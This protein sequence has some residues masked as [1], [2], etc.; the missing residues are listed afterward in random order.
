MIAD[1]W[2]LQR[3]ALLGILLCWVA[4]GFGFAHWDHAAAAVGGWALCWTLLAWCALNAGTLW[5]N[6]SVDRDAGEV[7]LGRSVPLPP[8][9]RTFAYGALALAVVL[10][11][12]A[13]PGVTLATALCAALALAYS[14]PSVLWKGH[15]VGGPVV[16]WLG[17]GLLTP[18]VGHI[19]SGLPLTARAVA[20]WLVSSLAVLG[21]YFAAQ[22][23]QAQE[24]RARGYRTLVATHGPA[25]TV[26]SAKW[27]LTAAWVGLVALSAGGWLPRVLLLAAPLWAWVWA[28]LR[29]WEQRPESGTESTARE[30]VRRCGVLALLA[31]GLVCTEYVRE[32]LLG[33]PVAGQGTAV[34]FHTKWPSASLDVRRWP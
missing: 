11:T 1:L 33:L 20:V 10:A 21:A 22:A 27:L 28:W 12:G 30:L 25:V 18:A 13:G 26:A 6:A 19:S 3:P 7:L 2:Q 17:Y 15:P 5:L 8:G 32:S 24:D 34:V 23:F 29:D 31:F 16:N 14:H 9:L 4:A